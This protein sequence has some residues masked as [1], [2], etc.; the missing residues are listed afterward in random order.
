MKRAVLCF[1]FA[2]LLGVQCVPCFPGPFCPV[3]ACWLFCD[4]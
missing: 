4:S 1:A 3:P 2:L